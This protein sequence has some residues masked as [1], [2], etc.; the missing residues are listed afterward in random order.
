MFSTGAAGAILALALVAACGLAAGKI[1]I[2][3]VSLGPGGIIFAGLLAGRFVFKTDSGIIDFARDLGIILFVYAVGLQAGPSLFASFAKR[4]VKLNLAALSIVLFSFLAAFALCLSGALPLAAGVGVM[5]GAV[6]NTPGLGAAQQTLSEI[7]PDNPSLA[8]MAGAGYA[9]AYPCGVVGVIFAM[10]L[11]RLVFNVN[12][13]REDAAFQAEFKTPPADKLEHDICVS[14]PKLE[15]K[16]AGYLID[17]A[18]GGAEVKSVIHDGQSFSAD[19]DTPLMT[20]DIIRIVCSREKKEDIALLAGDISELAAPRQRGPVS[21]REI[22]V[23]GKDAVGKTLAELKFPEDTG[24]DALCVYRAGMEFDP[25]PGF[26]V[27]FGDKILAAGDEDALKLAARKLGDSRAAPGGPEGLGLFAGI[28]AG[29]LLGSVP[30][31]IPG[32]PAPVRLGV[33]GG[34]LLAALVL[35]RLRRSGPFCWQ[36]PE[37]SNAALREFGISLFLAAVGLKSGDVFFRSLSQGG[38]FLWMAAGMLVAFGPLF[39]TACAARKFFGINYHVLCG[40]MAGG[41]TNPPALAFAAGRSGSEA[42][43]L[44]YSSVYV[45]AMFLRI[46]LAQIFVAALAAIQRLG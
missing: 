29:L 6:T 43:A 13:T 7:F 40:A 8:D 19:M 2:R 38:G 5:S 27:K 12:L 26:R 21:S 15:G 16:S 11:L 28:S 1:K 10:I 18:D 35:G 45:T 36:L 33:A 9:L 20:G 41:M 42:P 31:I 37:N 46:F 4:G 25:S 17:L 24:A 32:V 14:N 44:S 34:P 23:T 3:E 22:V 30:L 39:L